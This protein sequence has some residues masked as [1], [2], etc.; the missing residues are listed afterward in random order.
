MS[1][2]NAAHRNSRNTIR[3]P[4]IIYVSTPDEAYQHGK[5][6]KLLACP[7]CRAVGCLIR[8]GYLWGYGQGSDRI[9]R[10]RR[11]F[12][13]NRNR[14]TGCGRTYAVLLA[15]HLYRR[16]VNAGQIG[17]FL[18]RVLGG[19]GIRAGWKAVANGGCPSNGYKVWGAFVRNQTHIRS[20][21]H[22]LARPAG[23][24]IPE[25][26]LQVISHLMNAFKVGGSPVA[27]FQAASQ[28]GFLP[29]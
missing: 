4:R 10:G 13:S 18:R 9:R 27:A 29:Q 11:V 22:R 17:G 8:H 21:L 25:P 6:L 7:S 24:S 23:D 5:R 16:I 26:I 1:G 28:Q 3:P 12:C 14:R 20:G 2:P 15:L 19:D